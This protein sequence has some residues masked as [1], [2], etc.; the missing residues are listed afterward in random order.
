[1]ALAAFVKL[2]VL[3]EVAAVKVM[4]DDNGLPERGA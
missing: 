3:L 1:V 4:P 2:Q